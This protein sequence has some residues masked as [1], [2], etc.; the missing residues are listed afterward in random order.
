MSSGNSSANRLVVSLSPHQK[1]E[2]DVE[3]IMWGVVIALAPAF[4][5]SI[6]FYGLHAIRVVILSLIFCIGSEYLIQK[7]I[8]KQKVTAFDGSAAITGLLLAFNVPSGIPWWQLLTGSVVAVGV[9][10]MAFGGLGKNPFNPALVGRAFMLASFPIEM[11]TWPVPLQKV[12]TL[13]ADAVTSATPLGILAE[14]GPVELPGYLDLFLGKTGGCIGEV[15]ALAIIIGGIFLLYKKII[16]WHIPVFYLLSLAGFSGVL[17]LID[18]SKYADPLFHILA[19][20]AML[21]AW[22]M[23]TDMVTSPM[24]VKGQIIFAAAGGI[25]CGAIRIFGSYPEGCSYSILIM[26]AFVPLI[27]KY[28]KPKRFGKEV[29]YG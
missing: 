20:G 6:I 29:N 16:T 11:T 22:F 15:S 23:A 9:A 28:A 18:S 27:D 12:W 19:G 1:G 21:G 4:G 7:F 17:W 24:S 10:K 3:K 13:G 2:L 25:L 26:N 5:A 14:K 8:L